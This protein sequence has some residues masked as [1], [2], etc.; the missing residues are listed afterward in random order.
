MTKTNR[1]IDIEQRRAVMTACLDYVKEARAFVADKER[2][3]QPNP[4]VLIKATLPRSTLLRS[5]VG[6]DAMGRPYVSA[7]MDPVEGYPAPTK[8]YLFSA[9]W[10]A[11][12]FWLEMAGFGFRLNKEER[13][14]GLYYYIVCR[15]KNMGLRRIIKNP[16]AGKAVTDTGDYHDYREPALNVSDAAEVVDATGY[17]MNYPFRTRD[18]L[19]ELLEAS[20]RLR[21]AELGMTTAEWFAHLRDMLT[22]ADQMCERCYGIP[23]P[24]GARR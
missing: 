22:L 13:P 19:F 20:P 16:S 15:L 11:I 4:N 8:P 12:M 18:H 9:W 21:V 3:E 23:A 24:R 1:S 5:K 14:D 6:H 7:F 2:R 17:D 10:L